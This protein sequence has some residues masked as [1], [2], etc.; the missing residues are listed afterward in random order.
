MKNLFNIRHKNDSA[1]WM[2]WRL[3]FEGGDAFIKQYLKRYSTKESRADFIFRRDMTYCPA[4]A[5]A[6]IIDVIDSIFQRMVEV[7]RFGDT[8]YMAAVNGE[9]GGVDKSGSTMTQFIGKT[10]LEELLPMSKVGIWV[11]ADENRNPFLYLYPI[12]DILNWDDE[13]FPTSILLREYAPQL[14]SDFCIQL[15][16]KVQYRHAAVKNG[17]VEVKFLDE[18]KVVTKSEF[19]D[20]DKLPFVV[21]SISESLL[22]DIANYQIALLNIASSDMSYTLRANFPF[23]T[24]QY[25]IQADAM[26]KFENTAE[27]D[28]SLKVEAVANN[29]I[30]VGVTSGRRYPKGTERPA[31]IAPP[32]EPLVASMQKQEQLKQEL[33]VL[34]NLSLS[35]LSPTRASK[36]SKQQDETGLEAG[37]SSIAQELERAE[38]YIAGIW[39]EYLGSSENADVSYPPDYSLKND[40]DRQLEA[41]KD[42]DLVSRLPT[43]EGQR[44]L[45]KRAILKLFGGKVSTEKLSTILREVDEADI[46]TLDHEK[47]MLDVENQ[48]VSAEYASFLR[49]Y[50]KG[51][52]DEAAEE[53]AEKLARIAMSQSLASGS[54]L[55]SGEV[56]PL[57]EK[58]KKQAVEVDHEINGTDSG[59]EHE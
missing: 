41:E 25:D 26:K 53:H 47:L 57:S 58:E 12:E 42:L 24:E 54:P 22:K 9:N 50:P 44:E 7:R 19:L 31:F 14:D 2:K 23:Y 15:Q 32:T 56:S 52:A 17:K 27:V 20:F 18:N 5:K 34:I 39:H 10:V 40:S 13:R 21:V 38:K 3:T 48:L 4:F 55:A 37:L 11:D 36:E 33:R 29:A 46:L 28:S 30:E 43:K 8:R 49:G 16:P 45:T 35:N 1:S 6:A 59:V 51:Q